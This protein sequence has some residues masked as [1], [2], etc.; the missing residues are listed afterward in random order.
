MELLKEQ[1]QP[2][3]GAKDFHAVNL[4]D[5]LSQIVQEEKENNQINICL[6]NGQGMFSSKPP[7][8]RSILKPQ[9]NQELV[10]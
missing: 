1:K 3:F 7:V 4:E 10:A 8:P 5:E 9:V 6:K 2:S